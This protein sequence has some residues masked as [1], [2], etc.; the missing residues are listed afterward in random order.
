[1]ILSGIQ[2]VWRMTTTSASV[3]GGRILLIEDNE[4]NQ[5]LMQDFLSYHGYAVVAI[6]EACKF[7]EIFD[8]FQPQV[9]LL[10]LKLPDAD[11]FEL[12]EAIQQSPVWCTTP[13]IVVSAYAFQKDQHRA[14]GLGAKEYLVKPIRL[15]VLLQA[16]STAIAARSK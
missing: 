9:I 5:Q 16:I 13:V 14:L 1:M 4:S 15:S 12:L 11:G 10:D 8:Q 6:G 2:D 3:E 7:A